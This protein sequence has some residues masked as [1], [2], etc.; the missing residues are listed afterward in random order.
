MYLGVNKELLSYKQKES[1][2]LVV[3][4]GSDSAV[5]GIADSQ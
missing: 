2:G 1:V 5:K 4:D 3:Q